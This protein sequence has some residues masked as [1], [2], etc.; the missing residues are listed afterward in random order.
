MESM[1]RLPLELL[2]KIASLVADEDILPVAILGFPLSREELIEFGGPGRV[3]D[4]FLDRG[5]RD[6]V[7]LSALVPH[8]PAECAIVKGVT[9]MDRMLVE[10]IGRV[11][12]MDSIFST[13]GYIMAL[14]LGWTWGFENIGHDLVPNHDI[15]LM[16][17]YVKTKQWEK[18][19]NDKIGKM[20]LETMI[21]L[22]TDL[23]EHL[24][25]YDRLFLAIRECPE[26]QLDDLI[27]ELKE[28]SNC[29]DYMMMSLMKYGTPERAIDFAR[30]VKLCEYTMR[31]QFLENQCMDGF[32]LLGT[33]SGDELDAYEMAMDPEE[34][35]I[36]DVSPEAYNIFMD[37]WLP[38]YG[39]FRFPWH[40]PGSELWGDYYT[41]EALLNK[42][43]R[44]IKSEWHKLIFDDRVTWMQMCMHNKDVSYPHPRKF[45]G[46][47]KDM[48][49]ILLV[50][51]AC[52]YP[53]A[54]ST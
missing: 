17:Y 26:E 21:M 18:L 31:E 54:D 2:N 30:R 12:S 10:E 34:N 11:W 48:N 14:K 40:L 35:L 20:S 3:M 23:R 1:H 9:R 51:C 19:D 47:A 27:R 25:E 41:E 24:R 50:W 13:G 28:L 32:R 42:L 8:I 44:F 7:T 43:C 52:G 38:G 5:V 45:I 4:N 53:E 37:L 39:D 29:F 22:P 15:L 6:P 33:L 46:D 16:E 36:D 49:A